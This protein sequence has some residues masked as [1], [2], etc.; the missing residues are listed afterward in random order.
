MAPS[1]AP[2]GPG[3][4]CFRRL[5]IIFAGFFFG[6]ATFLG[7]ALFLGHVH[8]EPALQGAPV[9]L[10]AVVALAPLVMSRLLYKMTLKQGRAGLDQVGKLALFQRAII[11]RLA[12]LES[13]TFIL[14]AGY[15]LTQQGFYL[16]LAALAIGLFI[17]QR[18]GR[19]M[20]I[21]DLRLSP[22]EQQDL[23]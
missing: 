11:L 22:Q 20:F 10:F 9:A 15:M 16:L 13:A 21:C 19:R 23:R 7:L 8:K 2:D 17:M 14:L 5:K 4:Q 12:L 1:L 3:A 18:P 6:Q